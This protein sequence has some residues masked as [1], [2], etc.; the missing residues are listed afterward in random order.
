MS[1]SRDQALAS[2]VQL[3]AATLGYVA[4]FMVL[5]WALGVD[6]ETKEIEPLM[7]LH[8]AG[9]VGFIAVGTL[10]PATAWVGSARGLARGVAAYCGFLLVWVPLVAFAYPVVLR[11]LDV[12]FG[13]QPHLAWF[14]AADLGRWQ[15]IAMIATVLLIGPW[16]E[17]LAFR[18]YIRDLLRASVGP[19]AGVFGTAILFGLMHGVQYAAPLAL[20]G[21]L[22]GW[23]RE[24]TGG[25]LVPLVVHALHNSLALGVCLGF[26]E[27]ME[28]VYQ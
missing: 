27:L 19:R 18:G 8:G 2:L 17:E 25:L 4:A 14:L 24:R 23:L 11:W 16:M 6:V 13:A 10:L 12:P 15:T 5:R 22:F 7:L 21:L 20:L 9:C 28:A 26:P 1:S 3:L